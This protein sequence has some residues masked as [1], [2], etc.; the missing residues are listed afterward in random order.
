M[1]F[2]HYS[3]EISASPQCETSGSSQIWS[4]SG[5]LWCLESECLSNYTRWD[6]R[7]CQYHMMTFNLRVKFLT[8]S[9][10][11]TPLG[12]L[13]VPRW[14]RWAGGPFR[15]HL[16]PPAEPG[17][18]SRGRPSLEE[19]CAVQRPLAPR[20]APRPRW[21]NQ[22]VQNHYA[23]STIPQFPCHQSENWNILKWVWCFLNRYVESLNENW[24]VFVSG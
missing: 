12:P 1:D 20:P 22:W 2:M 9:C 18:C 21:R 8:K 19:R 15:S 17:H 3:R 24:T 6:T 4:C 23:Q 5:R 14:I 10:T 16:H 13:H 11:C 7:C